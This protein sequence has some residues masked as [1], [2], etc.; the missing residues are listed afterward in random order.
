MESFKGVSHY[1]NKTT[2]MSVHFIRI[3]YQLNKWRVV[4]TYS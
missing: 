4:F 2:P 3:K 1:W